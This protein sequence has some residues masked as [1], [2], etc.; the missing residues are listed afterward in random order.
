[1]LCSIESM[2][3]VESGSGLDLARG[4]EVILSTCSA[5]WSIVSINASFVRDCSDKARGKNVSILDK[6]S[7]AVAEQAL[8][9]L[10]LNDMT[11]LERGARSEIV[12]EL[13][14]QKSFGLETKV[15]T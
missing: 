4:R 6:V 10:C 2:R 11:G 3:Y 5:A 12:D 1:M 9:I 8:S 13:D 7:S 15:S 14:V